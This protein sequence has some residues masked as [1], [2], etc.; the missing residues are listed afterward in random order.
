M[1]ID[2]NGEEGLPSMMALHV[3]ALTDKYWFADNTISIKYDE[4]DKSATINLSDIDC[5]AAGTT[6]ANDILDRGYFVTLKHIIVNGKPKLVF[7]EVK[8][9]PEGSSLPNAEFKKQ[10]AYFDDELKNK[11]EEYFDSIIKEIKEYFN[12]LNQPIEE[13]N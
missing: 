1:I 10:M 13:W 11:I 3:P 9:K 7:N 5:E 12:N 2:N 8:S 4:E 6:Y